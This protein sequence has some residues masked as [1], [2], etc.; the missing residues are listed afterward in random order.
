MRLALLFNNIVTEVGY[1]DPDQ[2]PE[3]Q[4]NYQAIVDVTGMD[5]EPQPGW[6][7]DG[8]KLTRVVPDIT[9]RQLRLALILQGHSLGDI[10]AALDT[11]PEP[12]RSLAKTEWEYSILF[13]RRKPMVS[14]VGG[15]LGLTETQ[16]D[17]LWVFA[18][19]L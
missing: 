5:P 1:F 12:T 13:E 6:V 10:D 3:L 19:G 15:M 7:L 18:G 8:N 11:L 4:T 16:L 14:T 9:P 17:D 2:I